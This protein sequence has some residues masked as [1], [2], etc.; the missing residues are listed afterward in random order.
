MKNNFNLTITVTYVIALVTLIYFPVS[1]IGFVLGVFYAQIIEWFVHGWIQHH[2]FKIFKAYR[3]MHTYHHKH[4]KE[5]LSVQPIQYF[6]I[7]S[8]VLLLPFY[9]IDGFILGYLIAYLYI[10]IIH[11]DLHSD[12]KILSDW[13]WN[14]WYFKFIKYHHN[15]HHNGIKFNY[16]THSVTNSYL[17]I[18]FSKIKVTTMNNWI[19]KR[20]K[21]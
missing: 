16:T 13:L 5:P 12:K 3:D 20:L 2:P 21:I 15:A 1:I 9:N 11:Y 6:I 4:P 17:D 10:N 14:T 7:G 8:T 19:A 18:L